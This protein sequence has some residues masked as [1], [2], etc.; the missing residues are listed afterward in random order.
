MKF[1]VYIIDSWNAWKN[2]ENLCASCCIWGDFSDAHFFAP[3]TDQ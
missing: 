3:G 2:T 1:R